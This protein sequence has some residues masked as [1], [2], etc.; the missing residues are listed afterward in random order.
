MGKTTNPRP[1]ATGNR[2]GGGRPKADGERYPSG[3]LKPHG[4]NALMLERRRALC[5][6]V[7]MASCPLDA[8]F[9]NGWLSPADYGAGRAYMAIR[10]RAQLGA[11]RVPMQADQSRPDPVG[12]IRRVTWSE[13]SYDE[14]ARIWDSAMRDI[15]SD[16]A[17]ARMEQYAERAMAQWKAINA[18]MSH[19]E[20]IEVD[21]VCIQESWPQWIIQRASGRMDTT[22][23]TKRNILVAGLEAVRLALHSPNQPDIGKFIPTV[24]RPSEKTVVG[25]E[26]YV[27]EHGEA[28]LEVERVASKS[29]LI[30][31]CAFENM[32]ATNGESA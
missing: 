25:R 1:R 4:P 10:A 5:A 26:V 31:D 8:A 28:V 11:P 6:D 22:W 30:A 3:K 23:E 9:A 32:L 18:A 27:D 21:L 13:M 7:T 14:I 17:T 29:P 24:Q 2:S 12:D 16:G 15:G 20:R 19:S